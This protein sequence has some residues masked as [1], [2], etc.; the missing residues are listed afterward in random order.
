MKIPEKVENRITPVELHSSYFD[1]DT[2]IIRFP[3]DFSIE[4]LPKEYTLEPEFGKYHL[5]VVPAEKQLTIIRSFLVEQNRFAPEKYD[6]FR[7][8]LITINKAEKQK[9][10]LK[11]RE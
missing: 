4:S 9:L 2:L 10:I 1:C 11:K 6:A 3:E 7:E 5:Q 8:F